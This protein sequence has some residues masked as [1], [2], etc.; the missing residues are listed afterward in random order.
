MCW[1]GG[2][3]GFDSCLVAVLILKDHMGIKNQIKSVGRVGKGGV[4]G[5][6]RDCGDAWEGGKVRLDERKGEDE[7]LWGRGRQ[8]TGGGGGHRLTER[9]GHRMRS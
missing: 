6:G 1:L 9:R 8:G 5:E 4:V 2:E 3:E 7:C